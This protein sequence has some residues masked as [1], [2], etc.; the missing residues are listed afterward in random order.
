MKLSRFNI[1]FGRSDYNYWYNSLNR[2]FF[3]L[4]PSLNNKIISAIKDNR[5]DLLPASVIDKFKHGGFLIED[6][7][8]ELDI[9]REKNHEAIMDKNYFLIILPT[10]NCNFH[11]WYCI[12]DHIPSTMSEETLERIKRH[13]DY[14][15]D[16]ELLKLLHLEWFGGEP[17]LYFKDVVTP[18]SE[19]A[20]QKCS[21]ANISFINSSTTNGYFLSEDVIKKCGEL[22]FRHFQITL[23]GNKQSHDKVKFQNGCESTFSHVLNNINRLITLNRDVIMFLRINYTHRN[24]SE[25]IVT[26]INQYIEEKNRS[27]IM[28]TP[29]KVWQ[30]EIDPDF[31]DSLTRI[32]DRFKSAGYGVEYWNPIV[33]FIPCYTNK[34]YYNAINYNGHIVKCTA[35]DDLYDPSPKGILAKNGVI[36]WNSDFEDKYD[37]PTFENELCLNCNK[38]PICMGL[39]PR[40]HIKGELYCKEDV[41]DTRFEDS[42]KSFIDRSYDSE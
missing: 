17:F 7:I 31:H 42:I 26:E 32:L 16:K 18:I 35:C 10:L 14:M 6:D 20:I 11:C 9:V 13:I 34:K 38:L 3:R 25:E 33:D 30:E 29:R 5:Y 36:E 28:I 23:D 12:Q 27:N 15:I 19:Y 41:L 1:N 2:T 4:S 40:D 22:K 37:Q 21:E 39:C 8:N 24:V